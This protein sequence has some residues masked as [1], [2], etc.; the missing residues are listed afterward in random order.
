MW[1][2]R[3]SVVD[4]WSNLLSSPTDR[5]RAHPWVLVDLMSTCALTFLA[6]LTARPVR[7]KGGHS[8][9]ILIHLPGRSLTTKFGF[10]AY[11][12]VESPDSGGAEA[13]NQMEGIGPL[14]VLIRLQLAAG[15][16]S[17]FLALLNVKPSQVPR[18][19]QAPGPWTLDDVIATPDF[20]LAWAW[21]LFK[22]ATMIAS[23][24][25]VDILNYLWAAAS[26]TYKHDGEL[27]SSVSGNRYR[28]PSG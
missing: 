25:V 7:R 27:T 16:L 3:G 11:T 9:A 22:V 19:V 15:G 5:L 24:L 13:G 14:F 6:L 18:S 20:E 8:C 2:E 12:D 10:L 26:P 23:I 1:K 28:Y 21:E 17:A 4:Y